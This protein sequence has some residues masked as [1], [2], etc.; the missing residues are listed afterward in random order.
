MGESCCDEVESSSVPQPAWSLGTRPNSGMQPSLPSTTSRWSSIGG[1]SF[2]HEV[3]SA[4]GPFGGA[5]GQGSSLGIPVNWSVADLCGWSMGASTLSHSGI[6]AIG[7][8]ASAAR[9]GAPT[10]A[11]PSTSPP[12]TLSADVLAPPT[13]SSQPSTALTLWR[14]WLSVAPIRGSS[15]PEIVPM[16]L[17]A[18]A[19]TRL[20]SSLLPAEPHFP[21]ERAGA[22]P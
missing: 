2:A 17:P 20:P 3:A 7:A 16:L 18:A 9:G 12:A 14:I 21:H 5:V 19:A 6:G 1:R 8:E 11:S 13:K 4:G 10:E 15:L 22:R